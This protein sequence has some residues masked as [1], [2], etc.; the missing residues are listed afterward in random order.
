MER[1]AWPTT[2]PAGGV[3]FASMTTPRP[4]SLQLQRATVRVAAV[5]F[6]GLATIVMATNYLGSGLQVNYPTEWGITA[7]ACA[8]GVVCWM[9]PWA[10]IPARWFVP[11]VFG[12]IAMLTVGVFATGGTQSHLSVLY[13]VIVVFTASILEFQTAV[14]VLITAI[15]AS[16]LPL[17][18]W[19]WDSYYA[20]SVVLLAASM[21]ICAYVPALLRKALRAENQVA[22]PRRAELGRRYP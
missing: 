4:A 20:R 13:L 11:V 12:G 9:L 5:S 1:A 14:A 22:Q 2:A 7:I 19:G 6:W 18:I 16:A 10:E 3:V 21:V 15:L 17:A 8:A